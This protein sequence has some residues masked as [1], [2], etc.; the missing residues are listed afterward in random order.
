MHQIATTSNLLHSQGRSVGEFASS[1]KHQQKSRPKHQGKSSRQKRDDKFR[2]QKSE[3]FTKEIHAAARARTFEGIDQQLNLLQELKVEPVKQQVQVPI[4]T[5][6]VG[7]I[8]NEV[9]DFISLVQPGV[10][11]ANPHHIY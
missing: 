3:Q 1:T 10:V 9:F 5:R 11:Q 7:F 4:S 2:H 8:A 6:G